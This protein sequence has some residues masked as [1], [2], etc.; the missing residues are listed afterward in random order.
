MGLRGINH[1]PGE[2]E[3]QC[4][5]LPNQPRQTYRPAVTWCD[6]E[7]DLRLA[8]PG[9]LAG[10]PQ[11]TGHRELAAS[12]KGKAVHRCDNRLTTALEPAEDVLSSDGPRAASDCSLVGQLVDIG[13]SHEGLGT[14]AGDDHPSHRGVGLDSGDRVPQLRD[15]DCIQGVQLVWPVDGNPGDAVGELE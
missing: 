14:R 9:I 15:Y 8:E 7:L 10:D 1:L 2:Q 13:S 4:P 12:A 6:P 11:V 5:R 3:L